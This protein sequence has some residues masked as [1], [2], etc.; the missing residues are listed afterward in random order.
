M[1]WSIDSSWSDDKKL[2]ADLGSLQMTNLN[3][4]AGQVSTEIDEKLFTFGWITMSNYYKAF[5]YITLQVRILWSVK[6]AMFWW[7]FW[8][9]CC[10]KLCI[11]TANNAA[12][13]LVIKLRFLHSIHSKWKFASKSKIESGP[14]YITAECAFVTAI[15][16]LGLWA[17]LVVLI[18]KHFPVRSVS[19]LF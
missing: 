17:L 15:L 2:S 18:K 8:W 6:T 9:Q 16:G 7:E 3:A 11:L 12:V 5:N 1:R 10:Y 19:K 13:S 14:N 4:Y